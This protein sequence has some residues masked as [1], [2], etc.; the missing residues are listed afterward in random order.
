MYKS[1]FK[2]FFDFIFSLLALICLS[3][4]LLIVTIWLHFA[5]KGARAFFKNAPAKMLS[6]LEL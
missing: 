5:N 3:P 2:R 4:V 6:Y 1:Y